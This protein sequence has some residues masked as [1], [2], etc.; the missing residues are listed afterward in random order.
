M[1]APPEA[2]TETSV[3]AALGR[4][5]AGAGELLAD[6]AAHRAA[7][8]REV[9]DD[10]LAEVAVDRGAADHRRVAEPRVQ[11]GLDEP[12]GVRAQVEEAERVVGAQVLGLLDEAVRVG[13]LRDP[14]AGADREV[15]AAVRADAE[16]LARARRRGSATGSSGTCSGRALP[17]CSGSGR[18]L[19]S[20]ETSMRAAMGSNDL[21]PGLRPDRLQAE[22]R[23]R[24]ARAARRC[25]CGPEPREA[26]AHDRARSR[27]SGA[28][29]AS[30]SSSVRPVRLG[31][32]HG[33]LAGLE[34]RR[35]RARRRRRRRREHVVEAVLAPDAAR[36][37]ELRLGRIEVAR[38]DERDVRRLDRA[39]VD[40]ASAAASPRRCPTASSPAC[41]GRRA[42]RARRP[43]AG[44]G[45]RRG[46][47]PRRRGSSS[48]RRARAGG[49]AGRR[50]R[51]KVCSASVS[52][53]TTAASGYGS[54]RC[55]ASAIA[56]PSSPQARGTRTSPAPNV[57]PQEWHSYV[58]PSETAVNVPQSGQRGARDR[59]TASALLE[60]GRPPG[61]RASRRARRA[62]WRPSG[63]GASTPSPTR[64]SPRRWNS[65]NAC[66]QQREPEPAAAPRLAHP[67]LADPAH[68]E[69]LRV[70]DRRRRHLVAVQDG[71]EERRVVR[72]SPRSAARA[73]PRTPRGCGPTPRRRP[74]HRG[75]EGARVDAVDR[76]Q[77]RGPPASR[78]A[79][80]ARVEVD[81][82]S[83]S[84]GG[85][86]VAGSPR[87]ARAARSSAPST[88][89]MSIGA[90]ARVRPARTARRGASRCPGRGSPG[91]RS[92]PRT[93]S[94]RG[95]G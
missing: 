81:H 10:E 73:R 65:Q 3:H 58:G 67:R 74:P 26:R 76:R 46:P 90:P 45:A 39:R 70:A 64:C 4:A 31:H 56:S 41:S 15:V 57:R 95:R 60:E 89:F 19:C 84:S 53:S 14:R 36:R 59:L 72:R 29:A 78:A 49:R 40:A 42:R 88:P 37:E 16:V 62:A 68:P 7:H 9:H 63:S 71:P 32:E 30:T 55:A 11:L 28:A 93:T 20:I 23:A 27:R 69:A 17:L 75:V 44:R 12:L 34:R 47:R 21:R 5:V 13:E 83:G 35:R 43:R 38:A 25:R 24:A 52:A 18:F 33:Q 1:R 6:D 85:S 80:G 22:R 2:V 8:E 82:A 94:R 66:V 50:R 51:A 79:P 54:G 86:P 87:A 48:S 92:R 61:R 91:G 77:R